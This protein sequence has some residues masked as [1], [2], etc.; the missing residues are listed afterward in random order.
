MNQL[1][2]F[3]QLLIV[4][5]LNHLIAI[6]LLNVVKRKIFVGFDQEVKI[7]NAANNLG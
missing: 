7:H 6:Y 4:L 5:A 2:Q 3:I 1:Y